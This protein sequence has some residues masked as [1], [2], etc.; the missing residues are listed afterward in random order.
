MV[1][2]FSGSWAIIHEISSLEIAMEIDSKEG[3]LATYNL[4]SSLRTCI[5]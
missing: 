2:G 3:L 5:F 1:L 4:K